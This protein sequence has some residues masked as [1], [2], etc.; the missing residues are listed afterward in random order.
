MKSVFFVQCYVPQFIDIMACR[1]RSFSLLHSI[2]LC[3][4]IQFIKNNILNVYAWQ[5]RALG[6]LKEGGSITE[7]NVKH[8]SFKI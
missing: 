3:K 4:Y 6:F 8:K 7:Y 1:Y 5:K 2:L